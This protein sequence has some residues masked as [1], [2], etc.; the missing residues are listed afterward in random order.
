IY[1]FFFS[2]N[3]WYVME[4]LEGKIRPA[5][6]LLFSCFCLVMPF[7]FINGFRMWTAAHIFIYGLLP[8]LFEGRKSGLVIAV[9]SILVHYAFIVPVGVLFA[10]L[11]LGNRLIIYFLFFVTTFF[12]S[13]IN[14]EVF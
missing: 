13:E 1:G 6:I 7:W 11:L 5:T 8:Y 12:V 2:R 4:R 9:L 14:I 3:I 10:Y